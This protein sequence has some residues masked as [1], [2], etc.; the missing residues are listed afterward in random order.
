ME[1]IKRCPFCGKNVAVLDHCKGLEDCLNFEV[2][3]GEGWKVVVCDFNKGGCGH[4]VV[5]LRQRLKQLPHGTGGLR[6]AV[7]EWERAGIM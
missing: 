1:E 4:L 2:C 6:D 3:E 7:D 5:I